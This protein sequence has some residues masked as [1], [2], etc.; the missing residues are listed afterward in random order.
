MYNWSKTWQI[1]EKKLNWN[2]ALFQYYG[3]IFAYY[4]LMF[5][6]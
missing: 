5:L 3:I 1:Y 2:N 6:N 4:T